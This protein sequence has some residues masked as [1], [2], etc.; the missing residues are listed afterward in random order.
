M[1]YNIIRKNSGDLL[2]NNI[3][4]NT[5]QYDKSPEKSHFEKVVTDLQANQTSSLVASFHNRNKASS[6]V[7]SS[8]YVPIASP[9]EAVSKVAMNQGTSKVNWEDV[10]TNKAKIAEY[11]ERILGHKQKLGFMPDHLDNTTS[12]KTQSYQPYASKMLAKQ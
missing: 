6:K 1:R 7:I 5:L 12:T 2:G 3:K 11:K 4:F 9:S 10:T 8:S